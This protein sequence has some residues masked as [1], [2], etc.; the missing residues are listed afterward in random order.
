[1]YRR[2]C[3]HWR[4]LIENLS[5]I[6]SLNWLCVNTRKE[7]QSNNKKQISANG[8]T[9]ILLTSPLSTNFT[10]VKKLMA[11]PSL[12]AIWAITDLFQNSDRCVYSRREMA[13]VLCSS[14]YF[15]LKTWVWSDSG[16][17][18]FLC[19]WHYV[20]TRVQHL[21]NYC[22]HSLHWF[23]LLSLWRPLKQSEPECH[24]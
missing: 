17:V 24:M 4:L 6:F 18:M 5:P 19:C 11:M 1:M 16:S 9:E 3:C 22:F 21:K 12:L 10:K 2:Y 13:S 8:I 7:W 14:V 20:D 23:M 15:P